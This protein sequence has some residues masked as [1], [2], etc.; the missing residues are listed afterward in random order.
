MASFLPTLPDSYFTES[1]GQRTYGFECIRYTPST[2]VGCWRKYQ[3]Q[4]V[5]DKGFSTLMLQGGSSELFYKG[6]NERAYT[7]WEYMKGGAVVSDPLAISMKSTEI[8]QAGAQTRKLANVSAAT[9]EL[10]LTAA[11]DI[12]TGAGEFPLSLPFIR[13]FNPSYRERVKETMTQYRFNSGTQAGG[14]VGSNVVRRLLKSGGDAQLNDRLGG[15][16]QHNYE[17]F[18][19]KTNDPSARLGSEYAI[20]A[21]HTIAKLRVAKDLIS[22]SDLPSRV[23]AISALNGV[24]TYYASTYDNVVVK[25]G[26]SNVSFHCCVDGRYYSHQDPAATVA[27]L[28]YPSFDWRYTGSGG[29]VIDFSYYYRTHQEYNIQTSALIDSPLNTWNI[30]IMKADKWA[31]AN[32]V[33]LKFEY[34]YRLLSPPGTETWFPC[35]AIKVDAN[36]QGSNSSAPCK[37]TNFLPA[38]YI[39]L[40]VSNNLGR[41]LTFSSS[42]FE[43]IGG[44]QFGYRIESVK[45]ETG[46][47]AIFD[48]GPCAT[49]T[50]DYFSVTAPGTGQ[51]RYEY[52]ASAD[53]PDPANPIKPDYQLRRIYTPD[54]QSSPAVSIGYDNLFRVKEVKDANG[55]V[56]HYYPAGIYGVEDW[57]SSEVLTPAL[58]RSTFVFDRRNGALRSVDPLKRETRQKFDRANRAVRID[59]PSGV[60]EERRYDRRG[61]L[62]STCTIPRQTQPGQIGRGCQ[63]SLGDIVAKATYVEAENVITCANLVICNKPL[64]ETDARNNATTY[65]WDTA[66][67]QLTKVVKP[68]GA[69]TD[70]AYDSYTGTDGGTLRLLGRK[71][72]KVSAGQNIVTTYAYGAANKYVLKSATVDP[73]GAASSTTCFQFDAIGNLIGTTDPRAAAAC[74]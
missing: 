42:A 17:V 32:G 69:Q 65:S 12:V 10:S 26:P 24:L 25:M 35:S 61:N 54:D 16:W 56:S 41:S 28:P 48:K 11:P 29:D 22:S 68:A 3:L 71:T 14:G 1:N 51:T 4:D 59:L 49:F 27:A 44:G 58:A 73:D 36:Y 66:T 33:S 38:G 20:F 15:G 62:V 13:T 46:R 7:L 70:L 30:G 9:G 55:A 53:A 43:A 19:V 39:L 2:N 23:S 50:C 57:K 67:G 40:R 63:E 45:D 6:G 34:N 18:L 31:F 72:E 64:T 74:P 60:A 8:V 5:A 47:M 52:T 37:T 21:A